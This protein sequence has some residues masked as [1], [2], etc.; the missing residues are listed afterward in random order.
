[1]VV[2][3]A[4]LAAAHVLELLGYVMVLL[5]E[6]LVGAGHLAYGPKRLCELT[7]IADAAD[8]EVVGR[9]ER[10]V[11]VDVEPLGLVAHDVLPRMR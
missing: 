8:L 9:R 6:L 2:A 10:E 1:M 11:F 4:L 7:G 3:E 5:D